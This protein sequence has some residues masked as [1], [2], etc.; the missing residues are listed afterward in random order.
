M[1][2]AS[3]KPVSELRA[4]PDRLDAFQG[5][6]KARELFEL[7]ADDFTPLGRDPACGRLVSQQIASADS[8]CANIEEGFGRGSKK[9]FA[10][11][12]G[13]ARGSA[14]ET[15]GRYERMHRWIAHDR[16]RT[17]IALCNEIIAILN[18]TITRL[19]G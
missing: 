5:Y 15:R 9:E 4:V 6:R 8:I 7:V 10:T 13:Y 16:L 2:V 12:L 19:R 1:A 11:F 3:I 17:G 18:R 14:R